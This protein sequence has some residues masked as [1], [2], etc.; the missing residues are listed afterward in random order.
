MWIK[1]S[2]QELARDFRVRLLADTVGVLTL[3]LLSCAVVVPHSALDV[4]TKTRIAA[5]LAAGALLV[6][7]YRRA[8]WHRVRAGILVCEQCNI[9][10]TNLDRGTCQCGGRL[11]PLREMKWLETPTVPV[12]ARADQ[13]AANL[14]FAIDAI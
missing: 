14:A 3:A 4:S 7:W 13:S 5:A 12:K 11:T 10:K 2:T 6:T 1:K 9:V 8:N